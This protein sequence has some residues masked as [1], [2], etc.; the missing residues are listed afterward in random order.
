LQNHDGLRSRFLDAADCN[1][2]PCPASEDDSKLIVETKRGLKFPTPFGL[3]DGVSVD[4]RGTDGLLD[5]FGTSA[6]GS[7]GSVQL[8]P[9]C[10]EGKSGVKR[11]L[12]ISSDHVE[13]SLNKIPTIM[14]TAQNLIERQQQIF[15]GRKV[16]S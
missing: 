11:S 5:C 3:A 10:P 1:L 12:V 8:G 16:S 15:D 7:K 13:D 6:T 4:G 9:C 14:F 2:L